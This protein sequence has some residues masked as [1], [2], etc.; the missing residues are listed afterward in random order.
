MSLLN[1][2]IQVDAATQVQMEYSLLWSEYQQEKQRIQ[3]LEKE[4]AYLKEQL[5]LIQLRHFGKKS[6]AGEPI[7]E[8]KPLQTV[9][10]YVRH[11]VKKNQGRLIDTTGLPR[12][13]MYH[14]LNEQH[15]QCGH[16]LEK[17]GEETSEQ[18]EVVPL[19]LYMIEH[20]RG[21]YTCRHCNSVKMAPKPAAPIPKALAGGSLLTE[22]IINKYQYHLPLYRQSKI[23]ENYNACI[24]DNTL[25]NWVM[26]S[27]SGLLPIY[28]AF[29][30][31]VLKER[32]LQ[33]DE[34][35]IK[36]LK[37]EKTAYLWGYY[38]P[39]AGRGLVVFEFSLTRSGN[40]A[41]E[42]LKNFKGL[43]QTDGYTGYHKLRARKDITAFGCMTHGRRKF[44]EVFKITKNPEGIAAELIER[45]KPVYALEARM[46]KLK[47]SFHTRKRLR[48]KHAWPL[49]KALYVWIKKNSHHIPPKSALGKAI[50]YM[51]TQ[52]RY[53]IAYL[54]YSCV[55]IDTNCL[56]NLIRPTAIGKRNWLFMGHEESG[57]I[58]ALWFSFIISAVM[59]G[60]NPRIYI[61]FLLSKTHELRARKI[62][63]KTLLPHTINRNALQAFADQQ[64]AFA[65]LLLDSS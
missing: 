65:K 35:P 34:T 57:K 25:G 17:I 64:V 3:D 61:Y 27:G 58:H 44:S 24:L 31:T 4:N 49:L 51:L 30:E 60:L 47:V 5:L 7:V 46:R 42:R 22:I 56:E 37:P 11:Q 38:A 18:L 62:D 8:G 16:L 10:G 50:S 54:R 28:E 63:P 45:L 41:E 6:E 13:K 32:Y 40:F 20:I 1:D 52:W 21:K 2:S 23:L 55:E 43:L 29:W 53:L 36:V 15:C 39:H 12:Y 19:R 33:V 26:K 14:D 59:N 9:S 48:Q